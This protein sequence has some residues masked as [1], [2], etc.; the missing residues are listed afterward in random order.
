MTAVTSTPFGKRAR[1]SRSEVFGGGNEAAEDDR[2]AALAQ[3]LLDSL[4]AFLS[5]SS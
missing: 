1:S 5:F 3:K 2:A 4:A